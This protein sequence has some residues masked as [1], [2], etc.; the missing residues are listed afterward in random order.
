M[1][2]WCTSEPPSDKHP[3]HDEVVTPRPAR[4]HSSEMELQEMNGNENRIPRQVNL[5]TSKEKECASHSKLEKRRGTCTS[6]LDENSDCDVVQVGCCVD[7][8]T[9]KHPPLP[10]PH[11]SKLTTDMAEVVT[12]E[13]RGAKHSRIS[14]RRRQFLGFQTKDVNVARRFPEAV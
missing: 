1:F 4:S 2:S 10:S 9:N 7:R 14:P 12:L 8:N 6:Y 5:D 3:A 13:R 11:R